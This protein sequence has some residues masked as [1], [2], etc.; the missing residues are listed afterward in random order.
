MKTILTMAL[1][2]ALGLAP[3][4]LSATPEGTPDEKSTYLVTDK[5]A[6]YLASDNKLRLRFGHL[7]GNATVEVLNGPHTLYRSSIDLRKGAHQTFNLS[8]LESGSYQIRVTI[9]KQ[10]VDRTL[11]IRDHSGKSFRLD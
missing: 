4:A 10:V 8:E 9:G 11:V 7:D 6:M 5:M 2:C 1:A 3:K